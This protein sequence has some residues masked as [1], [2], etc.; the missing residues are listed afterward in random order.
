MRLAPVL[1]V[2]DFAELRTVSPARSAAAI[3]STPVCVPVSMPSRTV[4]PFSVPSTRNPASIAMRSATIPSTAQA[5]NPA[6][7]APVPSHERIGCRFTS[8]S[9][10]L[11]LALDSRVTCWRAGPPTVGPTSDRALATQ[12]PGGGDPVVAQPFR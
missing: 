1:S 2:I 8:S 9:L 10:L 11:R 6:A 3:A 7:T 4:V 12:L 5:A